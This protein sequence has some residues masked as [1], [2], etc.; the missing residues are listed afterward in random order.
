MSVDGS[1]ALALLESLTGGTYVLTSAHD[2]KRAGQI[3]R[4]V[5]RCADDPPLVCVA[6][7]KGHPIE[8]LIRDSHRF[9]VCRIDPRNKALVRRFT[10]LRPPDERVDQFDA[11]EVERLVT[12]SPILRHCVVAVDCQVVRHF[13]LEADH[14]LYIG[15]V[16]GGV[17]HAPAAKPEDRL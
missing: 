6:A 4:W 16:V 5:Q 2:S 3:V 15:L 9:G 7:R 12:G 10:A 17:V 1:A 13:D 11:V 14:E 8:P